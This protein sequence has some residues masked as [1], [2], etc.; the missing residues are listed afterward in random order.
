M[1]MLKLQ[2]ND[3]EAF[4]EA[5][6]FGCWQ[7]FCDVRD[8]SYGSYGIYNTPSGMKP[9]RYKAILDYISECID[10]MYEL[11]LESDIDLDDYIYLT[12]SP[13]IGVPFT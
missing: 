5:G 6:D 8:Y 3:F 10:E 4:R 13:L 1:K 9:A 2:F 11:M 12:Y 7:G